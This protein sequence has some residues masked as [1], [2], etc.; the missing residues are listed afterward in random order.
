VLGLDIIKNKLKDGESI[1]WIKTLQDTAKRGSDL[2]R[3]ILSFAR[4]L[5]DKFTY[6]QP[7]YVISEFIKI[8][9]GTFPKSI[10]ISKEISNELWAIMSDSTQLNQLLMNLC[11]N[12]RDAM[13]EG[14]NLKITAE[15]ITID[16]N[17]VKTNV[18]AKLGPY[19]MIN[20]SD[21]G[22]GIDPKIMSKIF[23]PFFT[24]KEVGKGTGLGLSTVFNIVKN[25]KGFL[26][27]YS[28][29]GKGTSFKIYLPAVKII[30]DEH[31]V[32]AQNI[33]FGKQEL[34]LVVDD[35]TAVRE[36]IR[37]TLETY[38]YEVISASN[39]AEAVA[40]FAKNLLNVKAAI[41][42]MIMPIMDGSATIQALKTINPEIKII[43]ASGF[44]DAKDKP[45][46][47]KVE[48]FLAKPFTAE[49]ILR[50]LAETLNS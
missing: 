25:H 10:Q 41:V 49:A 4:G 23:D 14:G 39:G 32:A 45:I 48:G 33:P 11:V 26:N 9:K 16:E 35:E 15:N 42:D 28:E 1:E 47:E 43:A 22:S 29:L 36:I 38:G 46:M 8:I 31:E 6:V 18:D 50:L 34:I 21:S 12:A 44:E 17:L 5:T 24:T 20:V 30:E 40:I 13:P 7:R 19:I 3:Q 2:V 37:A 27:V